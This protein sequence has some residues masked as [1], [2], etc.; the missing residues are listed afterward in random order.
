[1]ANDTQWHPVNFEYTAHQQTQSWME[2]RR[3]EDLLRDLRTL[4]RVTKGKLEICA[5]Y[6]R[7]T[8]ASNFGSVGKHWIKVRLTLPVLH[9]HALGFGRQTLPPSP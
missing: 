1:M 5:I 9:K 6:P 4:L 7:I 3:V 2:A 8:N